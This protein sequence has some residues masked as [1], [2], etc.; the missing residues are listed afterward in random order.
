MEYQ[1]INPNLRSNELDVVEQILIN[2]GIDLND[3]DHYLNTTDADI[4][5]PKEIANIHEGV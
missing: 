2:R 1:L 4:I 5:N 3:I